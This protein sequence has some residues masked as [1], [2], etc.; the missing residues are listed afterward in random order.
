[1]T[2]G[3]ARRAFSKCLVEL[4]THVH[5]LGLEFCFD[6]VTERITTKDP[7]SDHR[8]GSVHHLGLAADILLFLNGV[9]LTDTNSYQQLGEMWEELGT[10]YDLPLRWGGRFKSKD[11]NHFSMEWQGKK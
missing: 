3:Q 9:W 10:K 8:E 4:L 7:T 6:E 11:G 1:M 2:L 5:E